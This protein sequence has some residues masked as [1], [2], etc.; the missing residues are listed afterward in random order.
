M[1]LKTLFLI[2]TFTPMLAAQAV[3]AGFSTQPVSN[4]QTALE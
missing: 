3:A 4:E 2:A 1:T